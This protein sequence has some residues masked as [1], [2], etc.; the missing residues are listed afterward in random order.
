MGAA[1][2]VLWTD[3]KSYDGHYRGVTYRKLYNL[4]FR[5]GTNTVIT[6][7]RPDFYHPDEDLPKDLRIQLDKPWAAAAQMRRL[8]YA[9]PGIQP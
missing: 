5:D 2:D 9:C 4:S 3:G 1:V 6:A 8:Q 7:E